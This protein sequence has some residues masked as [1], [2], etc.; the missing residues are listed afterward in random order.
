MSVAWSTYRAA[1]PV[2]GWLAP[3]A[4]AFV[5]PAQ[6]A[7]WHERLAKEPLESADVWIHAA[8]LG[9]AGAVGPLVEHLQHAAP[10]ARLRLTATTLTGRERLA[11]SGTPV[12]LAPLDVPQAT[13]RFF[14]RVD[15]A[16]LILIETEL[17]PQWLIEAQRRTVP[18]V[19]ASARLSERSLRGYARLGDGMRELAAGLRGVLA[20]TPAD[21]ERWL[22]L[23]S[24]RAATQVVGN[25]KDDG[26]PLPAEDRTRLRATL[27]VDPNRPL[28]VLG[29]VRP[30]EARTLAAA[31]GQLPGELRAHWQVVAL[32]RHARTGDALQVEAAD[33]AGWR[34]ETR[35]GVLN[36]FY[37][38]ADVA[39]VGGSL[40]PFGGHNPME[41]AATG[42]AVVMGPHHASQQASVDAL[43][44]AGGIRIVEGSAEL[45]HAWTE[46]LSDSAMRER[47]AGAARGVVDERRGAARRITEW[48]GSEGLWPSTR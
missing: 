18:V 17:W 16:L 19:V 28:L 9:E 4:R 35:M 15:P 38:A 32:P 48:L 26:L 34:W 3:A 43:L 47:M 12:T 36:S 42:A 27:G 24:R 41:P 25:L 20:Q 13:R 39:F 29:S 2:L 30:G 44:H 37:R 46:L 33:A 31:W 11:A 45:G 5:P 22:A 8:S 1:G 14:E 10:S 6:R 40:E 21:A 23:G 7:L